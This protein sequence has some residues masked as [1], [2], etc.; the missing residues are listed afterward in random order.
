MKIGMIVHNPPFQGGIVQYSVLLVNSLKDYVDLELVGFNNLY[1]PFFYKGKLP[2]KDKSGIHFYKE[3][4]N[5]IDWFNPFSWVRAY[6]KLRKCEIIHLHWVSP[7]LAPLQFFILVINKLTYNRR[8]L[9]TCHNIEPH[10]STFLDK[11][12]TKIVFFFVNHFIVHA[13]QNKIRLVNHYKINPKNVHVIPHGTFAY[14]TEW[15]KETND[16]LRREFGVDKND[17]IILFFGYI[18]KYKGLK[19]LI[20]ALPKILKEVPEAKLVVAGELWE[21]SKIY[22]KEIKNAGIENKI[23]LF[24]NYI[25]DQ[26]VYKFFDLADICVLPYFNTEQTISGPLLVSIAFNKPIVISNVGGISEFLEDGKNALIVKGG[27]VK[28]LEDSVIRLLKDKNLQ[29][30]LVN[31][32]RKLDS[33]FDWKNVAD[34]TV[35]VYK[36]ILK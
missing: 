18:R 34:K 2:K 23:K 31:G 17:K 7:L 8:I 32:A 11:F 10:E 4:N 26:F 33:T 9:L 29:K 1:P 25:P 12:F 22:E 35:D 30:N 5:I 19:F 21:D 13:E 16:Q 20:R 24:T 3:S 15:R 14:F 28:E 6:F 27:D 36:E